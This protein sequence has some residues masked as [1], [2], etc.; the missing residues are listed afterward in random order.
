MP[1]GGVIGPENVP[2]LSVASGVWSL[3]ELYDARLANVWPYAAPDVVLNS[4]LWLDASDTSTITQSG[5]AV[6]QWNNKGSL[7]N[8]AQGNGALQPTTNATTLNG[9]NVI[10]FAADYLTSADTAAT[11][12]FLHDGTDYLI[13]VVAKFGTVSDPNAQYSLLGTVG[14]LSANVGNWYVY[15]DRTEEGRNEQVGSFIYRG[16]SGSQVLGF[17][18]SSGYLAANTFAVLTNFFDPNNATAAN[19]WSLY[20][21]GG[22]A[23]AS[24]TDTNAVS[25][26]NPSYTLQIGA[27]GNNNFTMT[28][29]IAELVIVSGA[30]A[31]DGNRVI[32]RDYLNLK[33]GVY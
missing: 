8:F 3:S 22:S 26:A 19:R 23:T 10:D 21:N 31:T 5:G 2:S 15:D 4:A 14:G 32:I 9:L 33:W 20:L 16:V 12:K 11:Y 25:T 7:G 30:D 13:C 27:G 17:R 6:S 1:N 18:T 29:S 24:N 28:G